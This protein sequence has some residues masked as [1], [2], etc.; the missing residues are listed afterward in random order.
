MSKP[1]EPHKPTKADV[2]PTKDSQTDTPLG[3]ERISVYRSYPPAGTKKKGIGPKKVIYAP[4]KTP[5]GT[6]KAS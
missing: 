3:S 6:Y 5:P 2:P 1:K 4:G